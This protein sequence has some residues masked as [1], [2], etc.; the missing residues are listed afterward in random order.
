MIIPLDDRCIYSDDIICQY[1]ECSDDCP[2]RPKRTVQTSGLYEKQ[3]SLEDILNE[4][5]KKKE[6]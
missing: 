3:L 6:N 5:K 4:I 1:S 2:Y